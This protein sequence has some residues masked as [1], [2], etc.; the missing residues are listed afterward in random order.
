MEKREEKAEDKVEGAEERHAL[1]G[2]YTSCWG[3]PPTDLWCLGVCSCCETELVTVMGCGN[4]QY[5]AVALKFK[6]IFWKYELQTEE[7]AFQY[8]KKSIDRVVMQNL[9]V[10]FL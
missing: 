8:E 6:N 7:I 4:A 5:Q 9:V 1:K 3:F 10:D 2:W